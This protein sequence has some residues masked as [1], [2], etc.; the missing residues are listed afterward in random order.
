[1]GILDSTYDYL[2]T[3]V[4]TILASSQPVVLDIALQFGL[5]FTIYLL[6]SFVVYVA[7]NIVKPQFIKSAHFET[8]AKRVLLVTAHPDDEC[9]FFGPFII[10]LL[11]KEMT[12]VYILCM[13]KGDYKNKGILRKQELYDSCR[14]LGVPSENIYLCCSTLRKD[15]PMFDW[16]PESTSEVIRTYV[17]T[18]DIDTIVTF[19]QGGVSG[20]V[21][22]SALFHSVV[23]MHKRNLLPPNCKVFLLASVGIM[24][25]YSGMMDCA[26]SLILSNHIFILSPLEQQVLKT[27]MSKHGSQW[28]WFRKL[29]IYFSRYAYINTFTELC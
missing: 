20:H 29:Y 21:N 22:H 23:H 18:L 11:K 16:K 12:L 13:S 3:T 7:T 24:R 26:L 19:D 17:E 14:V 25:K 8:R 5:Y 15:G 9:M 6:F 28:V 27:A 10:R 2:M 1:M 4:N